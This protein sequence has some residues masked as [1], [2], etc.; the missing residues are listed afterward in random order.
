MLRIVSKGRVKMIDPKI[1]REQT[2]KVRDS[3]KRRYFSEDCLDHF[4][5][6]DKQWR[7][8]LQ[9]VDELK[10]KR[11]KLTPKG[12]PSAE[13]LAELKIVSETIKLKQQ[14]LADIEQETKH[15]AM[16]IPNLL[17]EDVPEGK[18]DQD[19]VEI[20]KYG[21][22][23]SFSFTPKEH[24]VL[25]Q[26]LGLLEFDK[27]AQITGSRFVLNTGLGARLERSLIQFM[28]DT[29]T[30]NHNYY[31]VMPPV[32]VHTRSLEGTGQLPKFSDDCFKIADTEYWLSPT[33]EVQLTNYYRDSILN[34][35]DLP[36]Q[37]VAHTPCFRKEAG[38]YGKDVK[39]IIRQ[40]QFNKVELVKFVKPEESELELENLLNDA[41]TILDLLE[42]PYRVVKL[43]GGDVGFSSSKTYDLEV[44][45][46]S[47][48]KYREISSCSN[49]LDFQSRRAMIRYKSRE[50]QVNY[51]HTL[52]G[53]G[54]AVGRTLAAV[55]ENFQNEDGSISIPSA[56]Q[57][58]FRME[59]IDCPKI[60]KK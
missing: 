36:I 2:E 16:E 33:A 20:A 60:M 26:D 50:K 18:S 31:E 17:S 7:E 28:L 15:A 30:Q 14:G 13:Q 24:D 45:F 40:H 8:T 58:Y 59:K 12:K 29:H 10:A 39:G 3:L 44:W 27:A 53:S 41:K 46:P 11:N 55:L 22:V 34:E 25:A 21:T 42:L 9:E 51:L 5:S 1:L 47:Q 52:N 48:N 6:L 54:L 49:F 19:N 37:F 23:P 56:L 35:S 43:S 38:S 32:L 57:S 4:L